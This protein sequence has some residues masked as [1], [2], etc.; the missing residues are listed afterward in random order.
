MAY[1][2]TPKARKRIEEGKGILNF[3]MYK[4][5]LN[6]PLTTREISKIYDGDVKQFCC[7]SRELGILREI[8]IFDKKDSPNE[9]KSIMEINKDSLLRYIKNRYEEGHHKVRVSEID[10][11]IFLKE[12]NRASNKPRISSYLEKL[13]KE[14]FVTYS[15][16]SEGSYWQYNPRTKI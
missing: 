10:T 15:I 6:G 2:L 14:G 9:I 5:F 1:E 8:R 16:D 4:I 3:N 12:G 11:N 7:V 13:R